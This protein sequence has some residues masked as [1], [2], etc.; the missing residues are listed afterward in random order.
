MSKKKKNLRR[1][2]SN[3]LLKGVAA[4]GAVVGGGTIFAGNNAVYAA[5][6]EQD[7][8]AAKEKHEEL[9]ESQYASQST[10]ESLSQV[11]SETVAYDV[12]D[13]T[14]S[15]TV[16][17]DVAQ[18]EGI[19]TFIADFGED[20]VVV[21]SNEETQD[22]ETVQQSTSAEA[23]TTLSLSESTIASESDLHSGLESEATSTSE[24]Y[25]TSVSLSDSTSVEN[26][27]SD[28]V[29]M[30]ESTSLATSEFD[31]KYEAGSTSLSQAEQDFKNS[32]NYNAELNK[33]KTEIDQK[34]KE[35]D[36]IHEK[37]LADRIPSLNKNYKIDGQW[38][39]WYDV[40]DQ[41][42]V[43]LAQYKFTQ[44][45]GVGKIHTTTNKF[46]KDHSNYG[47]NYI[48][49][50]YITENGETH[51]GYFDYIELDDNG[52]YAK[53]KPRDATQIVVTQKKV[54]SKDQLGRPEFEEKFNAHL[55]ANTT[56]GDDY[57]SYQDYKNG[58][59]P[60]DKENM[61]E[62]N[63][64]SN[65]LSILVSESVSLSESESDA[66]ASKLNSKSLSD[67]T[68]DSDST[69][70]SDYGS[71]IE[72]ISISLSNLRSDAIKQSDSISTSDSTS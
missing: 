59:T 44:T 58:E 48:I 15:A 54:I 60:Y 40:A 66:P 17:G 52:N 18:D 30:S 3:N 20:R 71:T 57:F 10:T 51:T 64:L 11:D 61:S 29:S 42:A 13:E 55:N 49:I 43:K 23:S 63:S 39:S 7:V 2:K 19:T 41:L 24:S 5:E 56:K 37:L 16:N 72:S 1:K 9:I 36:K 69:S 33:I 22:A 45:Y 26:I 34:K 21:A 31:S 28:S 70:L 4:A 50:E 8:I 27:E 12:E 47:N 65:S 25:S 38:K 6:N 35:L 53:D 46:V 14:Y 32:E 67:S 62:V 68:S